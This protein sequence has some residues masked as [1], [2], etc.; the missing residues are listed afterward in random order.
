M[1]SCCIEQDNSQSIDALEFQRLCHA[2][3]YEFTSRSEV[4]KA[5]EMLDDDSSG[6][7]EWDEFRNWWQSN[8]KFADFV[9]LL[10]GFQNKLEQPQPWKAS[11]AA[12]LVKHPAY[13][14]DI[15]KKQFLIIGHVEL[16]DV[17][18]QIIN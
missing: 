2:L 7:I 6:T 15:T 10:A 14:T 5:V 13:R 3:G 9:H 16:Q 12:R 4:D 11:A 18:V 8:D 1:V 17:F